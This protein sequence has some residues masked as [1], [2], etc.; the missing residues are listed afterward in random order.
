MENIFSQCNFDDLFAS[1]SSF[2][3]KNVV[4]DMKTKFKIIQNNYLSIECASKPK[5]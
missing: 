5:L 1:N 3:V 4:S 2:D